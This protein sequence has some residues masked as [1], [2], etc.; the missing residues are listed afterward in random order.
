MHVVTNTLIPSYLQECMHGDVSLTFSLSHSPSLLLFF[1]ATSVGTD[2]VNWCALRGGSGGDS[3]S[4]GYLCGVL[5]A[6]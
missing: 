5:H 1:L 2:R 6:C 3:D 4:T